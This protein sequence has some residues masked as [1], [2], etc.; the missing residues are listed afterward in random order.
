MSAN[1]SFWLL[2]TCLLG[3]AVCC[4]IAARRI[5]N[6][7]VLSGLVAGVAGNL[8][9]P[10]GAGLFT[11]SGGGLGMA[12]AFLGALI[13][14]AIFLPMYFLKALGAGDAKLV[15]AVGAFLG[16]TQVLGVALLT[17][18]AGGVLSLFAMLYSHALPRVLSNL[19]LMGIVAVAGRASGMSLRDVQT[20]GR[21]PYAIAIATGTALQLWLA[22]RGGWPF[23]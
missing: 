11:S 18:I 17:L 2:L 6:W 20:T 4:D 23:V 15:S 19:R 1:W 8:F 16:P 14:L 22:A 10:Q 3:T 21:L 5:P 7:L 12:A 9:A 13:G